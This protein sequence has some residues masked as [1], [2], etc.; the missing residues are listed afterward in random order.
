MS[1][2]T[3]IRST[4]VKD[5]SRLMAEDEAPTVHTLAAYRECMIG[6]SSASRGPVAAD[7]DEL[8]E[9]V[10]AGRIDAVECAAALQTDLARRNAGLLAA[11][12]MGVQD[13]HQCERAKMG[14][15]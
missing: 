7:A 11:R 3:A 12:R 1:R 2:V 4:D 8:G 15:L 9:Q 13:R 10:V 6:L 5:Y 14:A